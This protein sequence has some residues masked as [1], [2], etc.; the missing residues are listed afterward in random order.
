MSRPEPSAM[1]LS[2]RRFRFE[3]WYPAYGPDAPKRAEGDRLPLAEAVHRVCERL[4]VTYCRDFPLIATLPS[5]PVIPSGLAFSGDVAN[6]TVHQQYAPTMWAISALEA[7]AGGSMLAQDDDVWRTVASDRFA[8]PHPLSDFDGFIGV[9]G[10]GSGDPITREDWDAVHQEVDGWQNLGL[11]ARRVLIAAA[12][13]IAAMA[14]KGHVVAWRYPAK[15]STTAERMEVEQWA[16]G[17]PLAR[18]AACAYDP[19]RPAEPAV[20][21]THIITVED[22]AFDGAMA[23]ACDERLIDPFSHLTVEAVHR[24]YP[25]Q[26]LHD[27]LVTDM[28]ILLA[29]P[30]HKSWRSPQLQVALPKLDPRYDKLHEG[31]FRK[32]K[33]SLFS[34]GL[35]NLTRFVDGRPSNSVLAEIKVIEHA[36][37]SKYNR[38]VLRS[39]VPAEI[40]RKLPG[41]A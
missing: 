11:M 38:D 13:V 29:Q 2:D 3:E 9:F 37:K 16:M 24:P 7:L 31:I 14:L 32:A 20:A 15:G 6:A 35:P 34:L 23:A 21:P 4:L 41:Y 27:A 22:F 5:V 12:D 19:S 18:I 8:S 40:L 26:P 36:D 33:E 39:R 1:P 25:Y 30:G 28:A 17:D 10:S